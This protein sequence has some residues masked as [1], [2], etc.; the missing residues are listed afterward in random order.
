MKKYISSDSTYVYKILLP[1]LF[2]GYAGFAAIYGLIHKISSIE[3]WMSA[4]AFIFFFIFG[5]YNY[6]PIK[7]IQITDEYF[8]ISNGIKTVKIT[9]KEAYKIRRI[10]KNLYQIEFRTETK[11]GTSVT[12]IPSDYFLKGSGSTINDLQRLIV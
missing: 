9:I 4:I 6:I 1:I 8:Y 5:A 2:I 3:W 11:F 7:Y 12:F 10:Y